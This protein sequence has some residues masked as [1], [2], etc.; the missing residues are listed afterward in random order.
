MNSRGMRKGMGFDM[1]QMEKK[2]KLNKKDNPKVNDKAEKKAAKLAA[3]QAKEGKKVK[4]DKK[5]KKIAKAASISKKL[6]VS[7]GVTIALSLVGSVVALVMLT[8]I[9][10]QLTTFYNQ[11]YVVT[12]ECWEARFELISSKEAMLN[13]SLDSDMTFVI[14][15]M[16]RS[17]TSLDNLKVMMDQMSSRYTG[18]KAVFERIETNRQAILAVI[19]ELQNNASFG[20]GEKV[21]AGMKEKVTPLLDEIANELANIA[22]EQDSSA[23][24]SIEVADQLVVLAF[25]AVIAVVILSTVIAMVIG[26][27][28]SRS[29]SEPVNEIEEAAQKLAQGNLDI[30]IDYTGND[31]LGRLA[32][33]MRATFKFLQAVIKDVDQLLSRVSTGD[34]TTDTENEGVYIGDFRSLIISIRKLTEQLRNTLT[35]IEEHAAQVALGSNQMSES[36]QA[37]AEGATE[38][39]GAVQ[40]L[41]AMI[42]TLADSARDTAATTKESYEQAISYKDEAEAGQKNMTSL[43]EAMERISTTSTQIEKII[44]EIEDIADQTNLLSLNA[45]IEAAR[46][47][48]AGRGFAVVADQIGKLAADSAQSAVNTREMI[49]KSMDEINNGNEITNLTSEALSKVV[50]GINVIAD[51]MQEVNAKALAQADSITQVE[52]GIE[53]ITGVIESNSAAAEETSATSEE[54]L[55]QAENLKAQVDQF[56]LREEEPEF[57]DSVYNFDDI[58][59]AL[60]SAE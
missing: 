7:Y 37:L 31:E 1:D 57:D 26:S 11:N 15:E 44:A 9:G 58:E 10:G 24:E 18:D 35:E 40:E 23:I 46:A 42:N 39:A 53:Q 20:L 49:Q 32:D 59:K 47:G 55:A 8:Y 25:L 48:E 50:A 33:S 28:I 38:Q 41:T 19:P 52:A 27:K 45:S 34:F 21:Y 17:V 60:D 22:T 43:L 5:D 2:E 36:A 51:S 13:A 6:L 30:D 56:K 4:K 29:I 16:E 12:T 3:K 14:S 54:L